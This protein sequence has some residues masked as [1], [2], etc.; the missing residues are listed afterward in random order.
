[1][2]SFTQNGR[3]SV[4]QMHKVGLDLNFR[5]L[6]NMLYTSHKAWKGPGEWSTSF[7]SLEEQ[8][9]PLAVL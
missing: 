6:L 8:I 3:Y 9:P 1:M 7:M 4:R 5:L 2:T